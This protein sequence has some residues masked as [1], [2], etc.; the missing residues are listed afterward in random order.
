MVQLFCVVSRLS[1]S[2][3]VVIRNANALVPKTKLTASTASGWM[4]P[5]I[6]YDWRLSPA[7]SAARAIMNGYLEHLRPLQ[8]L[9]YRLISH[10][11]EERE[12][13]GNLNS[14][15]HSAAGAVARVLAAERLS[16]RGGCRA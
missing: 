13:C 2:R 1:V 3:T 15:V 16:I 8:R 9:F 5:P 12:L 6:T 7:E 11:Q 14:R 4:S 10:I